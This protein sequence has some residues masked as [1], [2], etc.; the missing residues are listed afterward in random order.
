MTREVSGD[1]TQDEDRWVE[2][3]VESP[4]GHE[5]D[6][7]AM[8]RF[9]LPKG[10]PLRAWMS[11]EFIGNFGQSHGINGPA[12][13]GYRLHPVELEHHAGV[14]NRTE[15]KWVRAIPP[16][17]PPTRSMLAPHSAR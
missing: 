5:T 9:L 17:A 16:S 10:S 12:L 8:L 2:V 1:V 15:A 14:L 7:L 6:D 13:R 4:F 11:F 3:V